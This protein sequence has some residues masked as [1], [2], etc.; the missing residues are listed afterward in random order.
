MLIGSA[1]IIQVVNVGS[2]PPGDLHVELHEDQI[3]RSSDRRSDA[4]DAGR[5]GDAKQ[6]ALFELSAR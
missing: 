6:Q 5:V 1:H 4:A 2:C 3:R